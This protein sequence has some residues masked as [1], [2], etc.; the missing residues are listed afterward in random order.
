MKLSKKWTRNWA[1]RTLAGRG[2]RGTLCMGIPGL[3]NDGRLRST[4]LIRYW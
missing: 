2:G 4:I 1:R 3:A